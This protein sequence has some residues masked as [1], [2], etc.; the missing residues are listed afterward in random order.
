MEAVPV[1]LSPDSAPPH[2]NNDI[3]IMID[4]LTSLALLGQQ[5]GPTQRLE[6]W[7]ARGCRFDRGASARR[8]ARGA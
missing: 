2:V 7:N 5:R 4:E 8:L 1:S 3:R 6:L